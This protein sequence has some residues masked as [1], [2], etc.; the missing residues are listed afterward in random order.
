MRLFFIIVSILFVQ[1]V[2]AQNLSSTNINTWSFQ[3]CVDYALENNINIKDAVLDTNI[4]TTNYNTSKSSKLPNLFGSASQNFSSGNTIDPITSDFVTEK[5]NSTNVG[6]NSSVTLF[7]GNQISNQI[8]QNKIRVAQSSLLA[9]EVK[10]SIVLSLLE[11][12]LQALYSKEDITISEN[13]LKA[14][15]KE[16]ARAKARLDAGEITLSDYSEVQSQAA[17]NKYTIIA[18][19]NSYQQYIITLKQLLE[20]DPNTGLNIK[21]L[22]KEKDVINLDLNK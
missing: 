10:N 1:L 21:P 2:T 13:N 18:A 5:V 20:L 16:L 8:K 7:Q 6:I 14:T 12:Y 17:T 11:N 3:D 15:E 9:E 4:A 19:K 22:D